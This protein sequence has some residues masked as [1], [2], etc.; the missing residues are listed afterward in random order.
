MA[1]RA[2][3]SG[4]DNLFDDIGSVYGKNYSHNS[5]QMIPCDIIA[6][7]PM[8]P[9]QSF[10]AES[11]RELADSIERHGLLQ[12]IVVKCDGENSYT[13]IAGERRLRAVKLLQREHIQA[14]VMSAEEH[15][16]RELALVENI[17]RE[18]LN[19]IELALCYEALLEEHGLTQEQL[20][21]RIHKSRVQ[22]TNT[23]RLLELSELSKDS[24]KEGK[25]TQ[26]HAK[27]LIGLEPNDEKIA[28][29]TILGQ[30][31]N[32][33]ETETLAKKLKAKPQ[34]RPEITIDLD[35]MQKLQT[36]LKNYNIASTIKNNNIVLHLDEKSELDIIL[37]KLQ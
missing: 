3:G 17:Q 6:T 16:M 14:I 28:L 20:A 10:S 37:Q 27:I 5:I 11:L 32:V 9:R 18:D 23:L 4:L 8:Q 24:I 29:Q 21:Q 12:P 30:K 22:I 15:K 1:K 36:T 25:I 13:L 35:S 31:L 34:K 26:G 33:R 2:L 7:N 19:P